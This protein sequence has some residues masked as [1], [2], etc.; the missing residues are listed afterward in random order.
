[1]DLLRFF[2][3]ALVLAVSPTVQGEARPEGRI[4]EIP[5]GQLAPFWIQPKPQDAKPK[6][7]EVQAFAV[8]ARPVT[9]RDWL[10]FLKANPDWRRS[11]VVRVF[12]DTSYLKQMKS[13]FAIDAKTKDTAPVTNVSWFAARAY[14]DWLGMRLPTLAEWEYIAAANTKVRDATADPEFL[15]HVLEWYSKPQSYQGLPEVGKSAPNIYGVQDLHGLIWEWVEDFNSNLITGESRSDG[16]LD[17]NLFCGAGG[18]S[19]GDKQNY[20]AFMRFAFRASL[21]GAFTTWNLGFRCAR[22]AK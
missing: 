15:R 3:V 17:R 2:L 10:K 9:N 19:G 5:A 16:S 11:Q 1:M 14:C 12:A 20:A 8:Q 22:G 18:M 7:F 21:K 13:D 6:P 4:V